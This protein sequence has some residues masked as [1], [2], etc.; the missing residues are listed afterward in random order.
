MEIDAL[1]ECSVETETVDGSSQA[2]M[3][4]DV[5]ANDSGIT[6]L[7]QVSVYLTCDDKGFKR[8]CIATNVKIV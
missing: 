6:K 8:S 7:P 1:S 3:E 2:T 5:L 4:V